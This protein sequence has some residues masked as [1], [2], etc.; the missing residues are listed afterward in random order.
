MYNMISFQFTNVLMYPVL[1]KYKEVV[2]VLQFF[3]EQIEYFS[4]KT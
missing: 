2:D 1:I 3:L 4:W